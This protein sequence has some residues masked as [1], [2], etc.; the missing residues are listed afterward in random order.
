LDRRRAIAAL[1]C[2][3]GFFSDVLAQQSQIHR[4]GFL[5]TRSRSTPASPDVYYDAFALGMRELGYV[6]GKNLHID[7]RFADGQY[8]RIPA[9]ATELVKLDLEVIVTHNT[10][11]AKALQQATGRIPIVFLGLID[12]VGSGLAASL[13]RPGKNVTGL[14]GMINEVGPKQ[15]ELLKRVVA[16]ISRIAVLINPSTTPHSGVFKNMQTSA[17]QL[18]VGTVRINA[19]VPE[20]FDDAFAT[21]ARENVQG[22]IVPSDSFF[23]GQRSRIA[24]LAIKNRIPTVFQYREDAHAGGMMSYGPT[25]AE[26]YRHAAIYVDKILKGA[27]PSDLPIQQPTK[28]E[29]V[30]NMKTARALGI[31]IPTDL[32]LRAD[33]VIE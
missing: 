16:S 1:A 28:I 26:I 8:Q 29:F 4:I 12:P 20:D 32:L 17:Q 25:N 5:A 18:G 21:M 22:L 15:V 3:G 24:A 31:T 14:S 6:E 9:L 13:A 7:W 2:L 23:V 27:K 11:A 10:D 30:I 19:R 33:E